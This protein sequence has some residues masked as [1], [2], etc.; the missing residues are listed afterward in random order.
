MNKKSKKTI[1]VIAVALVSSVTM[2]FLGLW[3]H[4]EG[5][6]NIALA[7]DPQNLRDLSQEQLKQL[8]AWV[9]LGQP[10]GTMLMGV[11]FIGGM[12]VLAIGLLWAIETDF[13][14]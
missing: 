4:V 9:N 5:A 11:G 14:A 2:F 6:W 1:A 7:Q 13:D 3:L 8:F 10:V 12:L